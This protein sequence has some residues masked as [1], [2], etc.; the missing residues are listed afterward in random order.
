[1][2]EPYFKYVGFVPP[3]GIYCGSCPNYVRKKNTCEGAQIAC[4]ERK[5]KN[6]YHCC[7]EKKGLEFCHECNSY[8]CSKFKTFA[9]R[10]LKYGQNLIINQ[11][12]IKKIGKE[13]FLS[14]MN[15][16]NKIS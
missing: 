3:C 14:E 5:C 13:Q 11:E 15:K 8:P 16:V 12:R 7:I 10:W 4:K 9:H 6:I 2:N 1:M